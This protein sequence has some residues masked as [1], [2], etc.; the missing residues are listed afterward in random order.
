MA[1]ER[2][3]QRRRDISG[4]AGISRSLPQAFDSGFN[5]PSRCVLAYELL[6]VVQERQ[7]TLFYARPRNN[8]HQQMSMVRHYADSVDCEPALRR[9]SNPVAAQ[10]LA[11]QGIENAFTS[12]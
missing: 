2:L 3:P 5:Q 1:Q 11:Q 7:R 4:C 8:S 6:T 10:C 9:N 12:L